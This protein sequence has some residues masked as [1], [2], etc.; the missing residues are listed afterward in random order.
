MPEG[1]ECEK[2]GMGRKPR[3][4]RQRREIF[5][6]LIRGDKKRGE[7]IDG[8]LHESPKLFLNR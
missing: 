7:N 2:R 6:G 3:L 8:K 5:E 4:G 1:K